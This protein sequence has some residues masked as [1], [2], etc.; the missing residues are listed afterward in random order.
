MLQNY[1]KILIKRT[2]FSVIPE[3]NQGQDLH[4]KILIFY[5]P[6]YFSGQNRKKV[7][8]LREQIRYLM[9]LSVRLHVSTSYT[10]HLRAFLQ[11]IPKKNTITTCNWANMNISY[12]SDILPK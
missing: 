11:A 5:A 12:R 10:G 3:Y 9:T 2:V 4:Q 7:H 1:N 8:K 6:R